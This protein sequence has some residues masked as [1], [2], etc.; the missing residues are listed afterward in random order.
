[1]DSNP[2]V[3]FY[4]LRREVQEVDLRNTDDLKKKDILYQG[5]EI[6]K[7]DGNRVVNTVYTLTMTGPPKLEILAEGV[8]RVFQNDAQLENLE[9]VLY[10]RPPFLPYVKVEPKPEFNEINS[11][12]L[13]DD[14]QGQI[15]HGTRIVNI[16]NHGRAQ[17]IRYYDLSK[18]NQKEVKAC[19]RRM[20]SSGRSSLFM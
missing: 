14:I 1:M 6:F 4:A 15:H 7:V 5:Y 10:E 12:E 8:V 20:L 17:I 18:R 11:E 16:E 2:N 13:P 19:I 9:D 3:T